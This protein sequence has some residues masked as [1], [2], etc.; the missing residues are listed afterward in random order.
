MIDAA[1]LPVFVA[2][3]ARYVGVA[4][5]GHIT[6]GCKKRGCTQHTSDWREAPGSA[7]N[8]HRVV[9]AYE[10]TSIED[11]F[12]RR[13]PTEAHCVMYGLL[14]DGEPLARMPRITKGS[15]DMLR[16][17]G[18]EPALRTL[19]VDVD[20]PEHIPWTPELLDEFR[21]LWAS[22]KGPL[23]TC[24]MHTSPKGYRLI[25]PLDRWLSVEEGERVLHALI[26]DLVAVGCHR[27]AWE[28]K[29]W[30]RNS[31]TPHH[32]RRASRQR[33]EAGWMDLSRMQA[34]DLPIPAATPTTPRR[35]LR[36]GVSKV[37]EMPTFAT[38]L[39]VD[40][41]ATRVASLAEAVL[42]ANGSWHE[43]FLTLAGALMERGLDGAFVPA[44]VEAVSRATGADD[45]VSDRVTSARSTVARRLRGDGVAGVAALRAKWPAV[46]DVLEEVTAGGAEARVRAQLARTGPELVTA[47][48]A[49]DRL[50]GA[51]ENAFGPTAIAASPGAGKTEAVLR[52]A[53]RLPI[54]EDRAAP[55]SRIAL[56]APTNEL[57]LQVFVRAEGRA[58][59]LFGP[60]SHV[61]P[62]G[63][64][65]CIHRDAAEPLVAGGQSLRR[66]FC[67]PS[68]DEPCERQGRCRA[69]RGWEGDD[70]AP[71]VLAPH[72]LLAQ[73][74]TVVG[75]RGTLVVDE[76]DP[77]VE[78][79]TLSVD[80]ISQ[81]IRH[82][83]D[84]KPFYARR[85]APALHAL[86]AWALAA[87]PDDSSM[88]V[89]R[90]VRAGSASVDAEVL[91]AVI[92]PQSE[93][94][95][96]EVVFAALSALGDE[97]RSDAP[98]I[99]KNIAALCRRNRA[100]AAGVGAASRVMLL[101][102][103]AL[104]VPAGTR[105]PT[106]RVHE[107]SGERSVTITGANRRLAEALRRDAPVILLDAHAAL[108]VGTIAAV[109]GQRPA[110]VEIAL[111]DGAP[112]ERTVLACPSATRSRWLPRGVLDFD[113]GIVGAIRS[114]IAWACESDLRS[115]VVVSW[116][117]IT[118]CVV[119][120]TASTL[121]PEL[122]AE[123][124]RLRISRPQLERARA[125]LGPILAAFEGEIHTAYFGN[126]KGLDHLRGMDALVTL[127]DPR[128][129]LGTER[130]RSEWAEIDPEG[131]L[132]ALA[133]AELDQAH[134][135]LRTV[136]RTRPARAL[137]VGV[138]V[139][140][141]WVGRDVWIRRLASGRPRPA[142]AMS[143]HDFAAVRS[144]LG[145]SVRD[146]ARSL[147]LSHET[148]RRYES[149]DRAIPEAVARAVLALA[150]SSQRVSPKPPVDIPLTRGFGDTAL[151]SHA[152]GVSVTAPLRGFR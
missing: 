70:R 12:A 67:E 54:L 21:A 28:A 149:G 50:V 140:A 100:R 14:V 145:V 137:H 59:R 106:I 148:V 103:R 118:L 34:V 56:T 129:N 101:V 147:S 42:A 1:K 17:E 19:V 102:Y 85:I 71:L 35:A 142:A 92:D 144:A 5:P 75:K 10:L 79:H 88:S 23:A 69:E 73:A 77:I 132:D 22:A 24:G 95:E 131:R 80:A 117:A 37:V 8:D 135:R 86:R 123:G 84:F 55:G 136:H 72:A 83:D 40:W 58:M 74:S 13:Y 11:L 33:V 97:P 111:A 48:E 127:G 38:G 46:A 108:H 62:G 121:T 138:V 53:R 110:L 128:P 16:A 2:P 31:R 124:Q 133:A 65:T 41:P 44:V 9:A 93:D 45:R 113:A 49:T 91:D 152:T 150:P 30:T 115:L 105:A 43:L 7:G 89:E 32:V 119:A 99:A 57:A 81:A 96:G 3:H 66:L 141:S 4:P 51:I 98:P 78:T 64:Y 107:S 112:I 122:V 104:S 125:L 60:L 114:A 6:D 39:P 90:A 61:G 134:G 126:L 146:L 52:R 76:P 47:A 27:S 139:P 36:R 82:L 151:E 25:Q 116:H 109:T 26:A 68:G 15:V 18:F 87:S 120:A 94:L 29:D 20:T 63:A 143:A 130:E